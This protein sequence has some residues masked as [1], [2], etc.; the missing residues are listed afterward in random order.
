MRNQLPIPNHSAIDNV[1][2]PVLVEPLA[3]IWDIVWPAFMPG[4]PT[5]DPAAAIN[6]FRPWLQPTCADADRRRG[7]TDA[8]PTLSPQQMYYMFYNVAL[9]LDI[10]GRQEQ[11]DCAFG[12]VKSV[13]RSLGG[14]NSFEDT[15]I[16]EGTH[17]A[18]RAGKDEL[19]TLGERI[20][21]GAVPVSDLSPLTLEILYDGN[22]LQMPIQITSEQGLTA[23]LHQGQCSRNRISA[24]E[25]QLAIKSEWFKLAK[26]VVDMIFG[27][28]HMEYTK[29]QWSNPLCSA[30]FGLDRRSWARSSVCGQLRIQQYSTACS[31]QPAMSIDWRA[32]SNRVFP[33]HIRHCILLGCG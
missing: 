23:K 28:D 27:L 31:L 26:S 20:K 3:S 4:G 32:A 14:P 11:G 6:L 12:L 29:Y 15:I 1:I 5:S 16:G 17:N 21:S 13:R 25:M 10:L 22:L 30:V 7:C 8:V 9:D 2:D 33:R 19:L 18:V 24:E